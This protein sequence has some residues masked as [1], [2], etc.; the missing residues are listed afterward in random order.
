MNSATSLKSWLTRR[1]PEQLVELLEQRELPYAGGPGLETP[2]R[3]AQHLLTDASVTLALHDLNQ[4]QIQVLAAVAVLAEQLHGPAP[5]PAPRPGAAGF[6]GW[7]PVTPAQRTAVP[8]LEP[9]ERAVPRARLRAALAGQPGELDAVLA[10]LA[11]RALLLPPHGT[12]LTVPPLLHLQSGELQGYGRP[13][14]VLLSAAYKA[15]E[16]HQIAA[17]LGL[18]AGGTRDAAQKLITD[19]LGD[20]AAVRQLVTQAPPDALDLLER[21]VPGPPLLRTHCF[22]SEH[23]QYYSAG[24]KFRFRAAGSGDPGTDWLAARGML[25]PIGPDLVELP[26][27]IAAALR[28]GEMPLGYDPEPP[29][30]AASRPLPAHPLGEAQTAATSTATRVELLLRATAA[31]PLA[32]RK[33][34]GIAVRDTRRLAKL[35]GAPEAQTRLWLDLSANAGLIA[36]HR[37]LPPPSRS[38]KP[39]PLPPARMLP[40]ARYDSWLADSPA[41]RLVPLIATWA[42]TPEVFSHWP[43]ESETP[44]ALVSPQDPGAVALRRTVLEALAVLPPGTGLGQ[45]AAIDEDALGDLALAAAWHRPA[46]VTGEP[47]TLARISATLTEAELLGVVAHGALTPVGHAVLGLLRAGADRYF[48][49]VPGAGSALTGRPALAAAVAA[50]RAALVELVP[51][52][53]TTARFQADLTAVVAGPAAPELTEL[54]GSVATRESE[55][56]AVVWRIDAASVRRALDSGADPQ[57]LLTRLAEVSEGGQPLPQPLSY[58]VNDAARTHGRIR[59]VRSACCIRSDDEA[60]VTELSRARVL[61]KLGLRRIAP[62]VLISTASPTDTLA[63]LRL[64]GYAPVLEAETGSTVVERAPQERAALELPSL[65]AARPYYGSGPGTPEALAAKLL[66]PRK[67]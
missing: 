27:E 57:E 6:A 54:L 24:S 19:R 45:A 47:G 7:S 2:A 67:G 9:S 20:R 66:G 34:G 25:I 38:R 65:T 33:A 61:A 40:T 58:L 39:A 41:E 42:V 49:A 35:I 37:D 31:G 21:L 1:T 64:G 60:L 5:V 63:A 23:G 16:I 32:V 13:V 44:V 29:V 46:A 52:P 53:R 36:P 15:A 4:V 43:D 10:E 17:D 55:G 62:T 56:H 14:D 22:V 3:L 8:A 30:V 48:P 26:Y 28:D 50:L 12:A 18:G 11:D 59:V 51:P